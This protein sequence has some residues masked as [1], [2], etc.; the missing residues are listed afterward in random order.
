MIAIVLVG[1]GG[2]A[3]GVLDAAE[4]IIGPRADVRAFGLAPEQDPSELVASVRVVVG[5]VLEQGGDVLLL[6]DLFGGSP[7]N[8]LAG[9]F[10]GDPHV[11]LV[12]GLN[13]PMLVEVMTSPPGSAASLA[14]VAVRAGTA[15]VV[16]AG[17]YLAEARA[18]GG[19]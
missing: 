11:E 19:A 8:A 12:C 1:H 3:G 9:A 2:Y 7:A 17:R 5:P 18:S 16:D 10:L 14:E 4:L 13:L 15:G 6:A